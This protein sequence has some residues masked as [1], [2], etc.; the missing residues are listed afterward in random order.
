METQIQTW[1]R[2]FITDA[3]NRRDLSTLPKLPEQDAVRVLF[4]HLK[5][6]SWARRD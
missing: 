6:H 4:Q 1:G 5:P 2:K 3:M